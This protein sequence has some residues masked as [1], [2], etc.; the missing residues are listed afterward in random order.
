MTMPKDVPT[1]TRTIPAGEFKAQCE[2]EPESYGY[3]AGTIE[4]LGDVVAPLDVEWQAQ[5]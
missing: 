5:R 3:M 4:I 1:R 2:H